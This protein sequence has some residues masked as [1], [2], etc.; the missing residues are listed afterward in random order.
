MMA[1]DATGPAEDG[2][3]S[4]DEQPSPGTNSRNLVR[5][6]K[7]VIIGPKQGNYVDPKVVSPRFYNSFHY[8]ALSKG[9]AGV[10]LAVGITSSNPGEGKTLVASN[11]AV[12]FAVANERET[13]LVDLNIASPR[14]HDIFGTDISPGL[15]DALNDATIQVIQ[16][17]IGHLCV[18]PAGDK[19]GSSVVAE[20]IASREDERSN[21]A[22]KYAV[23]MGQVAAFRDVIYSLKEEFEFVIVDM[24]AIRE[25]LFSPLLT[26]QMDGMIVVVNAN[27]TKLEDIESIFQVVDQSQVLGFV[28]NRASMDVIA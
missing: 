16:T 27:K 22:H 20:G 2:A 13:I 19:R 15:M 14:L 1:E 6:L 7:P 3:K 17:S 26:H 8:S 23:E 28:F 11:L 10:N 9:H 24:P 21:A 5:L 18:L 4:L 12:S 25:P